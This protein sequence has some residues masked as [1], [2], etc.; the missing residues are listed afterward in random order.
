MIPEPIFVP[1]TR[2]N[3]DGSHGNL[4]NVFHID[5]HS[6][7]MNDSPEKT[8]YRAPVAVLICVFN[9]EWYSLQRCLESLAAIPNKKGDFDPSIIAN[10]VAMDI[11]IVI[12]GVE[13]LKPCMRDYLHQLFG[14]DIP[15]DVDKQGKA[16]G[17]HKNEV[18][19]TETCVVNKRTHSGHLLSLIL[20]KHNQKKINSHEWGFR[21]FAQTSQ[22]NYVLTS[23][24]GTI[25]DPTCVRHLYDFMEANEGCVACTGRQRI[26][27]AQQQA[28]P[29]QEQ[30]NDS[31]EE[32]MLRRIQLYDFEVEYLT[33]MP[34]GSMLGF[35]EVL[36]GPCAFFRRSDIEGA[37]LDEYFDMGYK[38]PQELGLLQ[39]NLKI[40]EDRIPS[41]SAVWTGRHAKY[42]AWVDEALFFSEAELTIK[43]LLL[44][45]RRWNNGKLSGHV[46]VLKRLDKLFASHNPLWR[47][48]SCTGMAFIQVAAFLVSYLA[49]AIFAG[50]FHISTKYLCDNLGFNPS[51]PHCVTSIYFT[52]YILLILCHS[53]KWEDD[54]SFCHILWRVAFM[55]N[56]LLVCISLGSMLLYFVKVSN[57]LLQCYSETFHAVDLEV[58]QNLNRADIGEHCWTQHPTHGPALLKLMVF[59][60]VALL[61]SLNA[62]L[63]NY[64]SVCIILNPVNMLVYML[65]G[66]TYYAFFSAYA[67]SRYADLT[68]GQRP[69]VDEQCAL[70]HNYMPKC[71]RCNQPCIQGYSEYCEDH[72]WLRGKVRICKWATY[73]LLIVNIGVMEAFLYISPY[74]IAVISINGAILKTLAMTRTIGKLVMRMCMA[75]LSA[76][77]I[78]RYVLLTQKD[79]D[80]ISDKKGLRHT[81]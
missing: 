28:D 53:K 78:P 17:W 51:I 12:D 56:G 14:P 15:M 41:W 73:F 76:T 75:I 22:C 79:P 26:M 1:V 13:M 24:C 9:E 42:S 61:P 11:A 21:A 43:D 45:R 65:A 35:L 30:K 63:S 70:A 48:L 62:M 59:T 33:S 20:K 8:V 16:V 46:Y 34:T 38:R 80:F 10:V 74:F 36:P 27:S 67:I 71:S 55:V 60:S 6:S 40:C 18:K 25:F 31:L 58:R 52:L 81:V 54:Q 72:I 23:D 50:S 7:I 49:V 44:Q 32:S 68:W 3:H 4:F 66:P 47:K 39:S 5:E 19:P 69:T 64:T 77:T 57:Q 29:N 2:P 37:P